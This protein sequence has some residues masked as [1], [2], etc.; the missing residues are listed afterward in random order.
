MY[1]DQS[2]QG[3]DLCAT[4]RYSNHRATVL[5]LQFIVVY[6]YVPV[7]GELQRQTGVVGSLYSNNISTEVGSQ[8]EAQCLDHVGLLGFSSRNAQLSKLFIRA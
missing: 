2:C 3:L 7:I 4:F 8:Q 1:S 5:Q 6:M